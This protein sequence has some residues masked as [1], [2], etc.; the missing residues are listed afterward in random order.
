MAD[1][2]VRPARPADAEHVA[3]VQLETWK[4]AYGDLLPASALALPLDQVAAV[5]L[6]AIE[7]PPSPQHR[8]LVALDQHEVVG[9]A[10]S[11]P[12]DEGVE[13]STLLV[14]PEW[15][16]RGHGSRL[17]AACADHWR[18]DGME[19]RGHV[20]IRRGRGAARV[21]RVVRLGTGR[22]DPWPRHRRAGAP[23]APPPHRPA[24]PRAA[25]P[26]HPFPMINRRRIGAWQ[27]SG[28]YGDSV[29]HER[30]GARAV[31][32]RSRKASRPT[33]RPGWLATWRTPSRTP[34]MNDARS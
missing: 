5:W 3:H 23:P 28:T 26:P 19:S 25:P 17:L 16:R 10:A 14:K 21:P 12:A 6:N 9:F 20:G 2:S 11:E 4:A 8:V 27:P 22:A 30:A 34:G 13:L 18:G 32:Q 31:S 1:V 24:P 33:V 29:D 15:G 7:A